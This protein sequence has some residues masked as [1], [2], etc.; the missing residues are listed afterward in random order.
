MGLKV[1][2]PPIRESLVYPGFGTLV[3]LLNSEYLLVIKPQRFSFQLAHYFP[4]TSPA[5]PIFDSVF[6]FFF[7]D[8]EN[9]KD[10]A[11]KT[12]PK[13]YKYPLYLFNISFLCIFDCYCPF[14]THTPS[15]NIRPMLKILESLEYITLGTKR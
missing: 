14:T 8:W 2:F 10:H 13:N 15:K 9:L 11:S 3:L 5:C 1:I 12:G 7:F 6:F 4:Q